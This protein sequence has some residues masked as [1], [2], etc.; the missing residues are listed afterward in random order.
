LPFANKWCLVLVWQDF[1]FACG[2]VSFLERSS[3]LQIML[4]QSKYP[5]GDSFVKLVKEEAEQTV[6]R[7][8]HHPSVV[9]FGMH[10]CPQFAS[11]LPVS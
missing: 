9:I 4:S 10:T 7:L 1:M 5:A 8:R 6:K 2:Q 3:A 11:D